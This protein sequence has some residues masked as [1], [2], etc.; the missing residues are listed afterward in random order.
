[1]HCTKQKFPALIKWQHSPQQSCL[2]FKKNKSIEADV[3]TQCFAFCCIPLDTTCFLRSQL[4]VPPMWLWM[5]QG[6]RRQ[7][8]LNLPF[9]FTNQHTFECNDPPQ[10]PIQIF[11]CFLPSSVSS[12]QHWW[13]L[14]LSHMSL[15]WEW[16]SLIFQSC[17]YSLWLL[18]GP[19][20][21]SSYCG[22]SVHL[23]CWKTKAVILWGEPGE[24]S[25]QQ[26]WTWTQLHQHPH[27]KKQAQLISNQNHPV[28]QGY[29]FP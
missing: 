2:P 20:P 26:S 10:T 25:G 27:S 6:E 13:L 11:L 19:W 23:L 29:S 14:L 28:T 21:Y 18:K 15:L 24:P 22:S 5:L 17:N 7:L 8:S 4:A 9:S 3:G 1:M 12:A 16:Y